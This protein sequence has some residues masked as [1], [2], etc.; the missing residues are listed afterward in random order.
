MNLCIHGLQSFMCI[1]RWNLCICIYV[2]GYTVECKYSERLRETENS[3]LY[4][5]FVKSNIE[6]IRE[7]F[8][9]ILNTV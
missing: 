2:Y 1:N 6:N 4:R 5:E 9:Q 8:P 3:S 7:A